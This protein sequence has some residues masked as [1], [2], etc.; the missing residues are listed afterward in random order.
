MGEGVEVCCVRIWS[1]WKRKMRREKR[2]GC[3]GESSGAAVL[4]GW[5]G[6]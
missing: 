4:F 6:V 2:G 3:S 1:V 5:S